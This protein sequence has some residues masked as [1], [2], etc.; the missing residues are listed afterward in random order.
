MCVCQYFVTYLTR[1]EL[2]TF[3][4]FRRAISCGEMAASL[5]MKMTIKRNMK[6]EIPGHA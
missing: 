5:E 1:T 2:A 6:M 3:S 4:N